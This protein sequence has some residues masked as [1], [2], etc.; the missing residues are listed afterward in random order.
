[1]NISIVDDHSK[2]D[3]NALD[4]LYNERK[5]FR[6]YYNSISVILQAFISLYVLCVFFL[7]L[8]VR[9]DTDFE[10]TKE[11][12]YTMEVVAAFVI[13][14][15]LVNSFILKKEKAKFFKSTLNWTDFV[16]TIPIFVTLT[17]S[18][19][20]T[21]YSESFYVFW[22]LWRNFRFFRIYKIFQKFG[23]INDLKYLASLSSSNDKE[24]K[25]RLANII[26]H[27]LSFV[28]LSASLMMTFQEIAPSFFKITIAYDSEFTFDAALYY[29]II[30]V[31]TVGYGDMAP[32]TSF[33]RIII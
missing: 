24:I 16:T 8:Y 3:Q 28:I 23:N 10:E 17:I 18:K 15:D 11:R 12:L 22:Q 13:L 5:R 6:Y 25:F 31:T 29:V 14:L 9:S 2:K 30:T 33:A 4:A 19:S 1:M 21:F 20:T 26:F 27:I 32:E 7:S